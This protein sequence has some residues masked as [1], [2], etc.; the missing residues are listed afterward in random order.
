MSDP[1]ET[2]PEYE[3]RMADDG[4]G[5]LDSVP[6]IGDHISASFEELGN[7]VTDIVDLPD[8]AHIRPAGSFA[9]ADAAMSYLEQ[10]GMVSTIGGVISPMP[11]VYFYKYFDD[12]LW[13][14]IYQVYI[15]DES[16]EV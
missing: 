10:G 8:D 7:V 9:S 1:H 5:G 6:N 14:D 4:V 2:T 13:E 16:E 12:V 11:W 3:H 15:R